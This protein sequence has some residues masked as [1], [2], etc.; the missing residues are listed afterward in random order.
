MPPLNN[1]EGKNFIL[2]LF[3]MYSL[4]IFRSQGGMVIQHYLSLESHM[5]VNCCI[6]VGSGEV[7][8]VSE[9]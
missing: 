2:K 4:Y 5:L 8:R 6:S 9:T 3:I 1:V 7:E